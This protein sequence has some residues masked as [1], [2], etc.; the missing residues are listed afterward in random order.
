MRREQFREQK[1]IR[2]F[3]Y[4]PEASGTDFDVDSPKDLETQTDINNIEDNEPFVFFNSIRKCSC[5]LRL[6]MPTAAESICCAE[7][8]KVHEKDEG[9]EVNC[10]AI[11]LGFQSICLNVGVLQ[12]AYFS[13]RQHYGKADSQVSVQQ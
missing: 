13:L 9:K 6:A 1:G 10:I 7:I 3:P 8:E 2:P 4:E 5:G 12:T 11:Q